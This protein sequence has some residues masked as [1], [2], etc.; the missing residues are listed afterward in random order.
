MGSAPALTLVEQEIFDRLRTL[1]RTLATSMG[2]PPYVVFSDATLE[3]L[4]RQRPT[5]RAAM[6][7]VKGIG[8]KKFESFGEQFLLALSQEA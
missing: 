6:L 8:P 2:V 1:R 5:T 4:V 7:D 3:E